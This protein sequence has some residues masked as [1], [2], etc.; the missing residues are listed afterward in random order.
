MEAEIITVGTE[1]LMGQIL[2]TNAQFLA[3]QLSSLGINHYIET[4][5]GDNVERL[6]RVLEQA[7]ERSHIVIIT[8]GLGPTRDDVSKEIVS[9]FLGEDLVVDEEALQKISQDFAKRQLN[10]T[11]NNQKM[12]MTFAH[13]HSF[14]NDVGQA[15]GTAIEKEE[16]LYI[17]LPGPPQELQPMFNEE[18]HPFLIDHLQEDLYITSRYLNYYGIGESALATK[19]DTIIARQTNPTI[20]LYVNQSVITVRLTAFGKSLANNIAALDQLANEINSLASE[21]YYGEGY[22]YTPVKAL[23]SYLKETN[24]KIS[25]AE[26]L[27]GGAAADKIVSVPGSS[28]VFRG[29]FVTYD[30]LVKEKA[31][32]VRHE[33]IA[34]HGTVSEE[35]AQEMAECALEKCQADIALSFTGV[36]GPEKLEGQDVGTVFVGIARK[37]QKTKVLALKLNGS[38]SNI[39]SRA[40]DSAFLAVLR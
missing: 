7:K 38:R 26:S 3:Q 2:N 15:I 39:R 37:G 23:I 9:D 29:G 12:A 34:A 40:I 25:L 28:T 14:K 6:Q 1:L 18:V 16:R 35:C 24:Q 33:T 4:V 21:W 5:V 22:N 10:M 19:L 11:H 13:G 20:A 32:G 8:G 17:L 36:A 31:L 30:A 27:T